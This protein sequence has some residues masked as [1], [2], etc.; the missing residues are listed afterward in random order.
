MCIRN[1]AFSIPTQLFIFVLFSA[2]L[3]AL[4]RPFCR[5]FLKTR[6]EPTNADRIIGETA[7]VTEQIDNLHETGAVKVFGTV[8]TARSDA[9]VVI[10]VGEIVKIVAIRGV[11]DVDPQVA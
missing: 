3:L 9:D 2:V 5:K 8:W 7:V 11:N 4:R 10:P 1:R 6:S